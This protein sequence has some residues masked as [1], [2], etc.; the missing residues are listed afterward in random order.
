M[1]ICLH[2]L[3]SHSLSFR[4]TPGPFAAP[5]FR[6]RHPS[7]Y[8]L[9]LSRSEHPLAQLRSSSSLPVDRPAPRIIAGYCCTLAHKSWIR[10]AASVLFDRY[11]PYGRPNPLRLSAS[12]YSLSLARNRIC[13]ATPSSSRPAAALAPWRELCHPSI[14]IPF[15]PFSLHPLAPDVAVAAAG[16]LVRPVCLAPFCF[17]DGCRSS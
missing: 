8:Q 10:L 6:P 7:P 14:S 15:R 5:P 13:G 3:A 2:L 12:S 17:A 1:V 4:P 11:S 9:I 16:F